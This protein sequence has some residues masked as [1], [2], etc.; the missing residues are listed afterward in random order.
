LKAWF[1]D[2]LTQLSR[3]SELAR[4]IR[5]AVT[6]W[7]ALTRYRDDGQIEIDNPDSTGRRNTA[8][9]CRA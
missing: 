5:Y 1:E 6:R 3:K 7:I 2:R 8:F 4:A 9:M